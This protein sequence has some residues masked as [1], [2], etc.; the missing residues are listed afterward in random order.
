M[1]NER[2][3]VEIGG[4]KYRIELTVI[5]DQLDPRQAVAGAQQMLAGGIKYIIGPNVDTTAAVIVPLLRANNAVNVAYG[6]ARYLYTPPQRNS[7]LG[8]IASYQVGPIIYE[9][10]KKS[11]GVGS[12]S[13]I[14]RNEADALNQRDE[15]VR[16]AYRVGL[17]VISSSVIYPH[18]TMDFRPYVARM[19]RGYDIG[20]LAS[21][22]GQV[23]TG[24]LVQPVGGTPDLVVLSGVAP[25]D[26]PL[27]LIA[28]RELGYTGLVSTETAQDARYLAQAGAAADGFISLGGASPPDTRS[29]Y[30]NEF[31]R[32]Y[33]TLAGEW[34]DEAGT[35]VYALEM[36][37]RTLQLAG[38]AAITDGTLF[39]A[40][41]PTFAVDNPFLQEKRALRYGGY[42][43]FNQQRQ[44][45]VPMVVDEF[46]GGQFRTLFIGSVD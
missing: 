34:N 7:I 42:R 41:V 12:V 14:T 21:V 43:S 10:L 17:N 18:G 27:L 1:Y 23:V 28:L 29:P 22:R 26:T 31:V 11:K 24:G 5:D 3:G 33:E 45:G 39:L 38:P 37:L 15:G 32:R 19:L 46:R 2:G 8:M 20:D 40:T 9:Y 6:F 30:M 36:I 44:I 25:A 4:D 13:F 16:G 35:K